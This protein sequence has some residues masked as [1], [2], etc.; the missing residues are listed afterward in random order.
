MDAGT[1]LTISTAHRQLLFFQGD[2]SPRQFPVAVGKPSTPTPPGDYTIVNKIMNPGG[3]LGTRWMGLSI[4]NGVYGIHGTS[5]PAS[6]GTYASAGCIRMYNHDVEQVFPLVVIGTPVHITGGPLSSNNP[7]TKPAAGDGG[8]TY[9]VQP[10]DTLW[11]ISL[12]FG[13]S[14]DALI[15]ANNLANPDILQSGQIINIP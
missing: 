1:H 14:L 5:N 13:V 7:S 11:Q 10:G 12:R 3:M 8:K 9:T 4:P 2:R 15:Q 6:I